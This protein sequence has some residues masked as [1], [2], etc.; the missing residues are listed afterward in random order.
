M[1]I[2]IA[3]LLYGITVFGSIAFLKHSFNRVIN[4]SIT[5]FALPQ[6][7]G[8]NKEERAKTLDKA[9]AT[10]PTQN[11]IDLSRIENAYRPNF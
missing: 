10:D 8:A 2:F 11:N 1:N 9:P 4:N 6:L 5:S 7:L 3:A